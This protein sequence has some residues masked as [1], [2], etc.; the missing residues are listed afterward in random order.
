MT[1]GAAFPNISSSLML[2]CSITKL[3][4]GKNMKMLKALL[5]DPVS[6]SVEE[7]EVEASNIRAIYKA[8]D[9]SMFECVDL[10]GRNTLYVDEESLMNGKGEIPGNVFSILTSAGIRTLIGKALV[11]GFDAQTGDSVDTTVSKNQLKRIITTEV[12]I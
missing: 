6:N 2:T 8:I 12:Y 1:L 7:T 11:L 10:D 9:A 5:I 3:T 4:K